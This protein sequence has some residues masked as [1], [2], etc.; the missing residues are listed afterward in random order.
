MLLEAGWK[1][2]TLTALAGGE[3][4]PPDLAAK[5]VK[6]VRSLWNMYGPTETTI[7]STCY[8]VPDT[9]SPVLIG[10]PVA[11][12][13]VYV[14]DAALRP[15]PIGIP[16]EIWI[17]GAGVA[18]GYHERDELTQERFVSDPFSNV[19]DGRM[20]RTGDQGRCLRDGNL[21]FRNRLDNQIKIRGFRVEVGE[22]EAVLV[23]TGLVKQAAVVVRRAAG[24]DDRLVAFFVTA[25]PAPTAEALRMKLRERLPLYMVPQHYVEL[26]TLPLTPN[27][28][29]DRKALEAQTANLPQVEVAFIAPRTRGEIMVADV[30]ADV[31]QQPRVAADADFFDLGGHSVLAMRVVARLREAGAPGLSL[32]DLFEATSPAAL[33]ARIDAQLPSSETDNESREV[34]VF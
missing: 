24:H 16:G 8:R 34:L 27:G 11:N 22:I 13:N 26:T 19:Q 29:I 23:E 14:L 25:G 2:S 32:R 7:W 4:L 10:R 6:C 17:G 31:L 18:I 21:E 15:V 12:T 33:G 30:F 28:K 9:G 1:G 5:L 3:A 20:Y